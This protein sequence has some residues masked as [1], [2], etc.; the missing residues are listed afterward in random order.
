MYN[1]V[2][3]MACTYMYIYSKKPHVDH[4]ISIVKDHLDEKVSNDS[5]VSRSIS[6]WGNTCCG[7]PVWDEHHLIGS[8][9]NFH[10]H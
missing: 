4:M 5:W 10:V 9:E 6:L 2:I 1:I 8:N 3:S 7:G